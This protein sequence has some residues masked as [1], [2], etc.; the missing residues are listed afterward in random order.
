ML[1]NDKAKFEKASQ[2]AFIRQ[3]SIDSFLSFGGKVGNS[4]LSSLSLSSSSK[5]AH[6]C[7]HAS[8]CNFS[9]D[10]KVVTHP[11]YM[12]SLSRRGC[13]RGTEPKPCDNQPI[14]LD[15]L[16]NDIYASKLTP[17]L[18]LQTF[19]NDIGQSFSNRMGIEEFSLDHDGALLAVGHQT[20][21]VSI[22]DLDEVFFKIMTNPFG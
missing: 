17:K 7:C 22:Y 21:Y 18:T 1:R 15:Q 19:S 5:R 8:A 4:V 14:S 16:I 12:T 13:H 9:R 11:L 2:L 6:L 3:Q 10:P 20:G